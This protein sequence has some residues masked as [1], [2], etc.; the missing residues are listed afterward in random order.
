MDLVSGEILASA[1]TAHN[2]HDATPISDLL[3]QLPTELT[4]LTADGAYDSRV[5]YDAVE[6]H[7]SEKSIL[8]VIPPRRNARLSTQRG[9]DTSHRDDT[10][11]ITQ[12]HDE[13][14][15]DHQSV[16]QLPLAQSIRQHVGESS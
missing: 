14:R 16:Q 2:I 6:K 1:L 12:Q 4:S 11:G 13:H 3:G 10:K 5:V 7:P 9:T 8:V 15:H